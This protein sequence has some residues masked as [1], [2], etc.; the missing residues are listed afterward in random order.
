MMVC[1]TLFVKEILYDTSLSSAI[2]T[3]LQPWK[4]RV[5]E[6]IKRHV[7]VCKCIH[8]TWPVLLWS[9]IDF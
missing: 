9:K 2:E 1:F 5:S 4:R 8:Y 7:G 6:F 3:A